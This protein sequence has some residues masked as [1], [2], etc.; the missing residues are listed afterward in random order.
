MWLL[1]PV[2]GKAPYVV[3]MS[4]W[5]SVTVEFWSWRNFDLMFPGATQFLPWHYRRQTKTINISQSFQ[6][7]MQL[8]T[9]VF[10][11]EISL[12]NWCDWGIR[13]LKGKFFSLKRE[14][15]AVEIW[16]SK[17]CRS[18]DMIYSVPAVTL[19]EVINLSR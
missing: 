15:F 13:K 11:A 12:V 5:V 18:K 4:E 3:K 7:C 6:D 14:H 9:K 2:G 19:C 17:L 1:P 16:F 10:L 8:K